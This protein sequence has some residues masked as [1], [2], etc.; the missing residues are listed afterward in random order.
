MQPD[1]WSFIY[2]LLSVGVFPPYSALPSGSGAA[3]TLTQM[4]K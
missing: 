4:N 3:L 2:L 1:V